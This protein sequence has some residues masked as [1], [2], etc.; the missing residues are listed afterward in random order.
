MPA[1]TNTSGDARGSNSLNKATQTEGTS[2]EPEKYY[3]WQ[4][5]KGPPKKRRW[6]WVDENVNSRLEEAFHAGNKEA[7]ADIDGWTYHY[8]LVTGTQ[9]SPSEAVM[10]REIRHVICDDEDDEGKNRVAVAVVP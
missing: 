8:D 10:T 2:Q 3:W 5:K 6:G 9:I 4:V 1:T 7:T